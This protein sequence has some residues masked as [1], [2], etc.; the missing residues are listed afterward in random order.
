MFLDGLL[1]LVVPP[2]VDA[3]TPEAKDDEI[4]DNRGDH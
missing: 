2:A 1:K 4:S 3:D